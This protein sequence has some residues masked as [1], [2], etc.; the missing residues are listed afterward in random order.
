MNQFLFSDEFRYKLDPVIVQTIVT[1]ASAERKKDIRGMT[2]IEKELFVVS[3]NS[4]EVEI[5]DSLRFSLSSRWNFRELNHPMAL[6]SCV[7][8]KCLYI[9]NNSQSQ[10]ILRIDPKQKSMRKWSTGKDCGCALS[11]TDESNVILTVNNKS[12]LNEYSPEGQL[13]RE[14]NLLPESGGCWPSSALKLANGHFVIC[15][16]RTSD[17]VHRVCMVDVDGRLK[18]S[19]GGKCGYTV[20]KMNVPVDLC[21]DGNEF[22]M[23]ADYFNSR[24]LLLNSDLQFEREIISH[25]VK[26]GLRYPER[27]L[28]D[29]SNGRLFVADNEIKNPRILVFKLYN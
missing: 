14:I 7:R 20:E 21:V 26:H 11:V 19:F 3:A 18:K 17:D 6:T 1:R 25:R 10:E 22:L 15:H 28:L 16:G 4:S 8:N 2:I 23:V 12:K 13:L 24:V 5:Y 27:I 9:L 29:E